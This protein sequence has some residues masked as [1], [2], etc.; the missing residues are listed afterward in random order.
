MFVSMRGLSTETPT[1]Q[2]SLTIPWKPKERERQAI[3]FPSKNEFSKVE[4][5][6]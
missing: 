3:H 5:Q 2:N 4:I 1:V 6:E